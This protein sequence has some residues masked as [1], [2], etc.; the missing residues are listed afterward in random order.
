M[1][2]QHLLFEVVSAFGTVGLSAAV[3]PSLTLAGKLVIVLVMFI[4]RVGV[5]SFL[6]ALTGRRE[7]QRYE[8][9]E[10]PVHIT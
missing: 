2:F 8:Y 4:G 1:P 10:E 7:E 3:T 6:L 5:L 9:T